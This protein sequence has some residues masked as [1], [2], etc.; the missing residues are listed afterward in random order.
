[1]LEHSIFGISLV[2]QYLKYHQKTNCKS[3][4]GS[5]KG[6][7]SWSASPEILDYV[8]FA[9]FFVYYVTRL[10]GATS[11]DSSRNDSGTTLSPIPST[12]IAPCDT[13]ETINSQ[14]MILILGGY[15]YGSLI[16][17][18]LPD[19]M[20]ILNRFSKANTG[21]AEAEIKLRA[22]HLSTQWNRDVLMRGRSQRNKT[23]RSHGNAM[24]VG[25]EE[26]DP[27]TRGQS[28]DSR[29]SIDTI[30]RSL[31]IS[32][33]KLGLRPTGSGEP[34]APLLDPTLCPDEV[35]LPKTFYL[36]I[37]PLRPPISS[38]MTIF[39]KARHRSVNL[40]GHNT[41]DADSN[42]TAKP[43]LAV[44]GDEDFFTSQKRLRKWVEDLAG[45]PSSS[46][47]FREIAGAGHFW[48]EEGAEVQLRTSIRFWVWNV[49]NQ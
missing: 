7:T 43:T 35:P 11:S 42:L 18:L 10:N 33:R 29:R 6:R 36:L 48:Q 46:F 41:P 2:T 49:L 5:S 3:G 13:L 39:S 44:Y 14:G 30:R 17:T 34:E 45:K 20:S 26:S 8:S 19:T 47:Q 21:S 12:Q 40:E 15:S 24:I 1:M 16:V 38:F 37:S 4:A 25:G 28:R 23:S 22:L 9:G 27:G 32:K 31:D